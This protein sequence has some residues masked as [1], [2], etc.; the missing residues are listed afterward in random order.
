VS[1]RRPARLLAPLA[2]VITAVALIAIISSG[3]GSSTSDE[4]DLPAVTATP[5]AAAQTKGKGA[6]A[7]K[8]YV[9]KPGDTPS[10]IAAEHDLSVD[11]L[12]E[13]NPDVDPQGLTPGQKLKLAP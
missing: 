1:D 8:T 3:G 9:V 2:L 4:V 10:A 5:T 13:L 7:R 6:K 11:R 12:L